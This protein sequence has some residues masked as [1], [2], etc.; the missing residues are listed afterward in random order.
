MVLHF[1]RQCDLS[2]SE[3][4]ELLIYRHVLPERDRARR[5]EAV[6]AELKT[7]LESVER[8]A[9]R[10]ATTLELRA[11]D[12][13]SMAGTIRKKDAEMEKIRHNVKGRWSAVERGKF[14]FS[15]ISRDCFC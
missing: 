9:A 4:A 13:Q 12:G 2:L 1:V 7:R 8:E 5:T 11:V 3:C 6:N 15:Y 14:K 10:L